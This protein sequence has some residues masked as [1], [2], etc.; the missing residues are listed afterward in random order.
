MWVSTCF[1]ALVPSQATWSNIGAWGKDALFP[2][3][4]QLENSLNQKSKPQHDQNMGWETHQ[5]HPS[6]KKE[7]LQDTDRFIRKE[8]SLQVQSHFT[9]GT[10]ML[11][12]ARNVY[13]QCI[14]T[15]S[16]AA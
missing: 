6:T 14:I 1:H 16:L 5:Q 7:K 10:N 8:K 9:R 2:S 12:S 3:L 11:S 15:V 13:Q 4:W